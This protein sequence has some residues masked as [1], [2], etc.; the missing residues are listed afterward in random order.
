MISIISCR[1]TN[2]SNDHNSTSNSL[3]ESIHDPNNYNTTG[4]GSYNEKHGILVRYTSEHDI[5]PEVSINNRIEFSFYNY[6]EDL[7][8]N[9]KILPDVF[10]SNVSPKLSLTVVNETE[11]SNLIQNQSKAYGIWGKATLNSVNFSSSIE[12]VVVS[13]LATKYILNHSD[14]DEQALILVRFEDTDNKLY[15]DYLFLGDY[16]TKDIINTQYRNINTVSEI[17]YGTDHTWKKGE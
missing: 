9:N 15:K 8:I 13:P 16:L 7:R 5:K 2:R 10:A 11:I 14:D 12:D 1:D 3:T 17:S 6:G 4:V